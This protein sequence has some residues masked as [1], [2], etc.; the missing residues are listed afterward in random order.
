MNK[1]TREI[2]NFI[3]L[4]ITTHTEARRSRNKYNRY[5]YTRGAGGPFSFLSF[6]KINLS[7]SYRICIVVGAE[8]ALVSLW[9]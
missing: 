3:V 9:Q 8:V 6:N 1:I 2:L 4:P 5:A 7:L